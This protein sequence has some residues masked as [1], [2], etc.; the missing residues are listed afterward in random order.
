M[1]RSA[2]RTGSRPAKGARRSS[3]AVCPAHQSS[4]QPRLQSR[5]PSRRFRPKTVRIRIFPYT[6]SCYA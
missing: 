3:A 2:C 5:S 6:D 4:A 1:L